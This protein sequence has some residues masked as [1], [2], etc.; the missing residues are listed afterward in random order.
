[1]LGHLLRRTLPPTLAMLGIA[2]CA[3]S[4]AAAAQPTAWPPKTVRIVVPFAAGSTPDLVGRVLADQL[5][6]QHPGS[7]FVIEN[8]PGASGNIGTDAVA[9]AAP[10]G[11][12]LGI[13]IPGPL[14]INT[15]LFP[16]LPYDPER[17][18]APVTLLTR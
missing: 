14:A 6:T 7:T 15:L 2:A 11:A 16:K 10:D 12:T 8:K 5:H 9:K 1:M 13:S 17:D 3:V 4:S 18:L